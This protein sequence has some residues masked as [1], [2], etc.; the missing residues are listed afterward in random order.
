MANFD[1]VYAGIATLLKGQGLDEST[2]A[3]DFKN[4]PVH[5]YANTFILKCLS[6]E[7]VDESCVDRMYDNQEW[8]IQVAFD[9]N[10]ANDVV[11]LGEVNRKKDTLI[12]LLDNPSSW[13][14]FVRL[15]KYKSW[16]I[17]EEPNYYILDIR[18]SIQDKYTY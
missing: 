12:T 8:Q 15:I 13:M 9:R 4:A 3:V 7:Q 2:Q 11:A 10:D 17:T 5:E 14:S 6:G 16:I 1:T 18:L